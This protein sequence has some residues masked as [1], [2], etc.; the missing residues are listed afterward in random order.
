[1]LLEEVVAVEVAV[2]VATEVATD[3]ALA[4]TTDAARRL[5]AVSLNPC[6]AHSTATTADI[7]NTGLLQR[8]AA[9]SKH[10]KMQLTWL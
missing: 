10:L 4:T 7:D 1:L 5:R 9:C 3:V 2:D 6:D 8:W